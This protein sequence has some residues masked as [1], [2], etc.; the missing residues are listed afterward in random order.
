MELVFNLES[1][2]MDVENLRV[3]IWKIKLYFVKI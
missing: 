2:G 3:V 1:V